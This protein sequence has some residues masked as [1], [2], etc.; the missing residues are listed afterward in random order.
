MSISPCF[1]F[2]F[3]FAADL[4]VVGDSSVPFSFCFCS[5]A[6][7]CLMKGEEAFLR[8]GVRC[9]ERRVDGGRERMFGLDF[10]GLGVEVEGVFAVEIGSEG[11]EC[12]VGRWENEW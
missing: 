3:S 1:S 4:S 12:V 6:D 5:A 10:L 7:R 2:C 9:L 8:L 11:G